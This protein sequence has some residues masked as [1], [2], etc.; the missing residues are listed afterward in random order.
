M[1]L[2]S[3]TAAHRPAGL[4]LGLRVFGVEG[5]CLFMFPSLLILHLSSPNLQ[6]NLILMKLQSLYHSEAGA[7]G[8]SLGPCVSGRLSSR[9]IESQKHSRGVNTAC[10]M[11]G[12]I[13]LQEQ[14]HYSATTM[15]S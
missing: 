6:T 2:H 10:E 11:W 9:L 3:A 5:F 1:Q 15:R 14:K 13:H 4:T 12:H 8:T 7:S